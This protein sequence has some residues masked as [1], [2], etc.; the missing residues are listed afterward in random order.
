VQVENVTGVSLTTRRTT[1]KERH[2]AIGHCLLGQI[3]IDD[4]SY[5]PWINRKP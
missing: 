5:R 3:V 4:E 2:L 1:K